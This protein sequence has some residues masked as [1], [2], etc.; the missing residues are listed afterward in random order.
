MRI[1]FIWFIRAL[2]ISAILLACQI[3]APPQTGG[4]AAPQLL[5][6][7]AGSTSLPV[8]RLTQETAKTPP[9]VQVEGFVQDPSFREVVFYGLAF[10]G[11]GSFL[12][13]DVWLHIRAYDQNGVKLGERDD[14]LDAVLPGQT[15]KE[16]GALSLETAGTVARLEVLVTDPGYTNKAP[17]QQKLPLS[18]ENTTFQNLSNSPHVTGLVRNNLTWTVRDINLSALAYDANGKLIG[19]QNERIRFLPAGKSVAAAVYLEHVTNPARV[20]L[21]AAADNMN[22]TPDIKVEGLKVEKSELVTVSSDLAQVVYLVDNASDQTFQTIDTL[23]CLYDAQGKPLASTSSEIQGLFP[24]SRV[25]DTASL[26]LPPGVSVTQLEITILP[27]P[28]S[29]SPERAEYGLPALP[30][31]VEQVNY[32]PAPDGNSQVSALI[33]NMSALPFD[34]ILVVAVLYDQAGQ[35]VGAGSMLM[36]ATPAGAKAWTKIPVNF[37]GD[38]YKIEVYPRYYLY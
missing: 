35:I 14:V 10:E 8:S 16:A 2:V 7:Q 15:Y 36:G 25:A 5:R 9:K 1:K 21:Y 3:S 34:Q 19:A 13:T 22:N 17:G 18:V 20:E 32:E 11:T 29:S 28:K 4:T 27:G 12:Q 24:S 6:Q 26:L 38:V 37:K 23:I 33:H 31:V 30:F